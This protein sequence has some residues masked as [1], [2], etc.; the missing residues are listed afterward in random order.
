MLKGVLT[1]LITP[2]KGDR[3]DD[4]AYQALVERQ[5]ESGVHGLVPSGTT[6]ES[7]TLSHEEHDL[8]V[9]LCIE[10]AEGR[11]PVIAGAGSNAT[12]EAIRLSQNAQKMGANG[13]LLVNHYYNKPTK[14]GLYAHFK[15]IHDATD[16]PIILYNIPGRSAIDLGDELIA[17]LS[18]LPRIR[19][20]K[21]ATGDLARVATLKEKVEEDFCLLSGEDMTALAFNAMGGQ[22]CI[23]V[24]SNIVPELCA[25]MHDAWF[26]GDVQKAQEIHY[27]LVPLHR[28]MFLET[29]PAPVKYA[30][31][32]MG[33]C[34]ATVRLPLV[35]PRDDTKKAVRAALEG[36]GLL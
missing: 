3:L 18:E 13:L 26:A 29:N 15:A 35:E 17:K 7:P 31:S 27:R 9:R 6:G 16:I 25:Q 12:R 21:D 14:E 33:L 8:V 10:A 4:K 24:T 11:V 5:I 28:A 22:G 19:G 34:D 1:A 30:A 36:A 2:F 23:S 20:L 32:L